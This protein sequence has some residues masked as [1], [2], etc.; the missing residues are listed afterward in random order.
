M[1]RHSYFSSTWII[2][3]EIEM[4]VLTGTQTKENGTKIRDMH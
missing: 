2:V 3:F 1:V 4:Q